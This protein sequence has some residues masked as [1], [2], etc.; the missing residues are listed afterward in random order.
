MKEIKEH[1][2]KIYNHHLEIVNSYSLDDILDEYIKQN[3]E[4]YLSMGITNYMEDDEVKELSKIRKNKKIINHFVHVKQLNFNENEI[5]K[6]FKKDILT[7]LEI[8]RKIIKQNKNITIYQSMFIEH[9]FFPY[10]YLTLYGKGNFA[11]TKRPTHLDFDYNNALYDES[12]KIDYSLVLDS[13]SKFEIVLEEFDLK[14]YIAETSFYESLS[15]VYTLKIFIF[16]N[17]AF[18]E[19][20]A[21]I[22]EG[23]NIQKPFFIFANEHDCEIY[24]IYVYN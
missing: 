20:E 22:F 19:I 17:K 15:K 1:L 2:E 21:S 4:Y 7:S 16:L 13:Y 23:I 6:S 9:D 12:C 3:N 10:A 14:N 5:I 11:I 8:L 18:N 24:N